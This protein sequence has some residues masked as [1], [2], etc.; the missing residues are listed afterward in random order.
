MFTKCSHVSH[1]RTGD[2]ASSSLEP[3]NEFSQSRTDPGDRIGRHRP[4]HPPGGFSLTRPRPAS[5]ALRPS[6]WYGF[7]YRPRAH[8]PGAPPRSVLIEA[9]RRRSPHIA[10]PS[11]QRS[12]VDANLERDAR[13]AP[14]RSR[15]IQ[16]NRC[17][18]NRMG[19]GVFA[20]KSAAL[21]PAQNSIVETA[22]KIRAGYRIS[23]NCLSPMPIA[24]KL[25]VH[26]DR[27]HDLITSDELVT[28]VSAPI[29]SAPG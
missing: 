8:T 3:G 10:G 9:G 5:S 22:M 27:R 12:W 15:R 1:R 19:P 21:A 18:R 4:R 2:P 14:T 25:S 11:R 29:L 16:T 26:P 6:A 17:G 28:S 23:F 7:P 24:L 13:P 20:R